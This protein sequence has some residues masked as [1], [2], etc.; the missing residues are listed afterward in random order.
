MTEPL[1]IYRIN[2]ALDTLKEVPVLVEHEF[3]NTAINRLYYACFYAV[4]AIL[5]HHKIEASTHAGVRQMFG[6]HFVKAEIIDAQH[7]HF[8]SRL[9]N[10]RQISDYDDYIDFDRE[11]VMDMIEPAEELI[12]LSRCFNKIAAYLD[13]AYP[14]NAYVVSTHIPATFGTH[15]IL[16]DSR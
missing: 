4:S 2:R 6:L 7:G 1:V 5:L 12:K 8:Y 14:D 11:R 3:L 16:P 13:N 9:F 15:E 10:I